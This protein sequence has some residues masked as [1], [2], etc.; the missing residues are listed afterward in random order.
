MNV[1]SSQRNQAY[2]PPAPLKCIVSQTKTPYEAAKRAANSCSRVVSI[3][4]CPCCGESTV[5]KQERKPT[6]NELQEFG[7]WNKELAELKKNAPKKF[8][9]AHSLREAG[10]ADMKVAIL[11]KLATISTA[12]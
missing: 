11:V 5:G 9:V 12:V 6:D 8:D 1:N 3:T 10:S 2:Q 7:R 4:P